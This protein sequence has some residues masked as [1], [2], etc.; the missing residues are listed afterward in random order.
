MQGLAWTLVQ[1][2]V[3]SP[4]SRGLKHEFSGLEIVNPRFLQ[5]D[6]LNREGKLIVSLNRDGRQEP[7]QRVPV[8]Y[9]LER[10]T[11]TSDPYYSEVFQRYVL[12]LCAPVL[13]PQ[14]DILGVVSSRFDLQDALG[15]LVRATR[16]GETGYAVL[17]APDAR[18]LA[19]PDPRRVHEAVGTYEAVQAAL[20]GERGSV[21]QKNSEGK[22][23]LFFY[24]SFPGPGKVN[25]KPIALLTEMGEN[26][27]SR[28]L[29]GL[30]RQFVLGT[31]VFALVCVLVGGWVAHGIRKPIDGLVGVVHRIEQG[32]L[33]ARSQDAGV[34]ALGRLGGALNEM[35]R[36]LQER[37][38]VKEL[39]GRYVTTQVSEEVL[40]GKVN[41]G[42]E[43]RRV[44]M[45]FSDIRNFTS[46]AEAMTPAQVVSFLNEYFSEMVEA[47]F[48]QGGV[49]DKFIGDGMMAVFGSFGDMPDHPRRAVA[50][51]L[52]M[53]ALL[54]K[55]NGERGVKGQAPIQIGIGIHTDEVIVGNIGSHRRLEYTVIG[56][57]VNT[58][59][60]VESLNKEFGT[61]I[62]ITST[63]H[64]EVQHHF[65][66]RLMP[67]TRLKGKS[68]TLQFY[69]VLSA[70]DAAA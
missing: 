38:R 1:E 30:R 15:R 40:K 28:P 10:Q 14:G 19:H 22:D 23:R 7:I 58:S 69:E 66:C 61:T 52:R 26:E 44:T 32:D 62:L 21:V 35:V 5:F 39:F 42:G 49:L 6:V 53:K 45:L 8:A 20:R 17:V 68:R 64:E 67:E 16:F 25:P 70:K 13:S 27:A 65:E 33:T 3:S 48:E 41:L 37:D 36:G 59:S 56:D 34:D 12:Q 24:R 9:A 60:R 29:Q 11:F 4:E 18:V 43:S 54:A 46:M 50:A 51:A 55:I 57:G 63:T 2:S 47:V 31:F